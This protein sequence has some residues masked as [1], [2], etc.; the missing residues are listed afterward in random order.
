MFPNGMI[1]HDTYEIRE[2]IG[3]GGGGAVYAAYDIKLRKMVAL[4]H[5]H[6]EGEHAIKAFG[7]E[8][9]LLAN[10]HHPSLPKV[11]LHFTTNDSQFLVMDLIDGS[12]LS[13][14][15]ERQGG[16]LPVEHVL[17]WADQL[18][19]VLTYLH[20]FY[21]QPIIHRDIKPAN[22]KITSR[23][24]LKL[25][26]FG[27]AKA[28]IFTN[29][30]SA[31][32]SVHGYTLTY[33]PPEQINQA[34][35]D[36][37]SDLY[38]LGAT[39]YHLL[40]GRTPADGDGKTADALA[41]TLAMAKR[42]PDPII[43]PQSFNPSIPDHVNQAIM[44]SLEIDADER[45]ASAE[46]FRLAL[47]QPYAP[48]NNAQTKILPATISSR[49]IT[50]PA[51]QPTSREVSQPSP[52]IIKPNSSYPAQAS[53]EAMPK[54][55]PMPNYKRFWPLLLIVL[56]GGAGGGWWLNRDGQLTIASDRITATLMA[57]PSQSAPTNTALAVVAEPTF[58]LSAATSEP[59]TV[60][61]DQATATSEPT[62]ASTATSGSAQPTNANLP[63]TARPA[64]TNRPAT[65]RPA[66]T[67]RPVPT[68]PPEVQP[69]NPPVAQ[70]TNPPVAQ[71]T[72]PPVDQPTNPSVV[73]DTDGD[74]IPDDRDACP[75]EPGDPSRNG[76]PKPKEQPTNLP[77]PT[78]PP[79]P[80][81]SNTPVP[82]PSNTPVPLPT[83]T[84]VPLPTAPPV[85]RP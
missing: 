32:H 41:R 7:H 55:Q 15:L 23:G 85:P 71:P 28:E 81:P 8:A 80:L 66:A 42:K 4:K 35:T 43:A 52:S 63:A 30:R 38:S 76:C 17:A 3:H 64:A 58:T 49:A 26:D 79:P 9:S 34:G 12:D 40:T 27:L 53:A 39:L 31:M 59:T 50:G 6:L 54:S 10:L 73:V 1:L 84:P 57:Q 20:T 44:R 74:T 68:N 70:P 77:Q 16:P 67:N 21:R 61:D 29:M 36:P 2:R 65:A 72:N 14:I 60:A 18:L 48:V 83:D 37:R 13:T 47:A 22:I 5:L 51:K 19:S 46:E 75:R 45:F 56:L 69:T 24:E 25:L 33:A 82:P 62:L 78:T 11:Y